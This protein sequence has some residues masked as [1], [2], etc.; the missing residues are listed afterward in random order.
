MVCFDEAMQPQPERGWSLSPESWEKLLAL[1]G[2]AEPEEAP[3]QYELLRRKLL[4]YF[5]QRGFYQEQDALC[6]KVFDRMARKLDEGL[7]VREPHGYALGI[8]RMVL[9]EERKSTAKRVLSE[10]ELRLREAWR[11]ETADDRDRH[12]LDLLQ[13]CL[14]GHKPETRDWLI[15]Y[16]SGSGQERIQNREK[17]AKTMGLGMNALRIRACRLRDELRDCVKQ[18]MEGRRT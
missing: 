12:M 6:D 7:E 3:R 5:G 13:A 2:G 10:P 17:I 14:K 15:E 18:R 8:A 11:E 1:L 9:L 16:Y 4:I